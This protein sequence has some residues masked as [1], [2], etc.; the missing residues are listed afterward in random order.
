MNEN[1]MNENPMNE[2]PMNEN[3]MNENP[4]NEN[5]TDDLD[6][7]Q[8]VLYGIAQLALGTVEGITPVAPPARVGEILTG[9]RAKGIR[10]ERAGDA[11]SIDLNVHVSYGLAIPEVALEAQQAV[12]E[13]VA[14]MTGLMVETVNVTVDAVDLP[15][16]AEERPA[17]SPAAL[18]TRGQ[19]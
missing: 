11:V 10:I 18:E 14:S 15:G 2:N 6:I 17:R 16:S 1:P 5:P 7:S 4:M 12:R 13:A 9:R 19:A 3:P 8:D